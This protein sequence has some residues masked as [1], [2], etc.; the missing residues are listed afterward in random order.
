[1]YL[2]D[3][4]ISSDPHDLRCIYDSFRLDAR[5]IVFDELDVFV[6]RVRIRLAYIVFV[7]W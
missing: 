4:R 7:G 1:M 2:V 5:R 3:P 6:R